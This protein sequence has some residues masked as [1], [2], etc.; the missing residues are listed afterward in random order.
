V[1]TTNYTTRA[2]HG[3]ALL[4][5]SQLLYL[6][7]CLLEEAGGRMHD[8]LPELGV[9]LTTQAALVH[10]L[11]AL[12]QLIQEAN[13]RAA[14]ELPAVLELAKVRQHIFDQAAPVDVEPPCGGGGLTRVLPQEGEMLREGHIAASERL[15]TWLGFEQG[16]GLGIGLDEG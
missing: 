11:L 2:R 15:L 9:K 8:A 4:S 3:S 1:D 10:S 7:I 14:P 16:L 5:P 12:P 6:S 13:V